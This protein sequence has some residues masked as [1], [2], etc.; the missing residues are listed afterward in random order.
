MLKNIIACLATILLALS[1]SVAAFGAYPSRTIT[2]IV[3]FGA[4]GATDIPARF[5]ASMMEKKLGQTVIVQNIAGAAGTQ[6]TAQ[7]AAAKPDGY[8][9]GYLPTG[10]VC[11]QPHLQNVPFGRDSFTFLGMVARQPV[12]LMSSKRAPWKNFEEMVETVRKEPNRH[13]IAITGT[14]N[15][16]HIPVQ[17]LARHFGLQFRYIPYRTTPELMK[18]MITGRVAL[19][20]DNPV[21]LSQF[22]VFGLI[23]FADERADNLD[24]P[25]AKEMGF[26]SGF[27]H[28][29]GVVAPKGM[30]AEL[31]E[32]L[33]QVIQEVVQSPEFA[34]EMA[35]INSNAYWMGAAE[36]TA[37][38]ENEFDIYGN[39]LKELM[40][41]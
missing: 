40:P 6:G 32:K 39:V 15:M 18:D 37:F 41:R 8:T 13:V 31:A 26:D 11:L 17:E 3:P 28:W 30:P 38:F 7:I 33:A 1:L 35:R 10:V 16:T 19:H 27:S 12:V 14:G 9:L 5:L 21:P 25:T 36:F 20:A 29:Q 34:T 22:D 24:F 4:G 2:L 23:Q